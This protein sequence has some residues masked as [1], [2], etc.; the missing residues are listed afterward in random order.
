M[1]YR[2]TITYRQ[3]IAPAPDKHPDLVALESLTDRLVAAAESRGRMDIPR[4]A[5]TDFVA[6]IVCERDALR[7]SQTKWW[8]LFLAY[9]IA[10]SLLAVQ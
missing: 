8:L 1:K 6:R 3:T 5:L 2:E 9:L 10:V 7:D 4:W